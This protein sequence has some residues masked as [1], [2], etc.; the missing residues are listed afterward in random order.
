MKYCLCKKELLTYIDRDITTYYC[1][2]KSCI[3][4]GPPVIYIYNSNVSNLY[5]SYLL[6]DM[7]NK[8]FSTSPS[9]ILI[10][11]D[12]NEFKKLLDFDCLSEVAEEYNKYCLFK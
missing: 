1:M 3:M 2:N 9:S 8:G 7:E 4:F 6:L 10:Y 5:E 11:I 12:Y